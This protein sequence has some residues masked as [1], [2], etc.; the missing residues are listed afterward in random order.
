MGCSFA[1]DEFDGYLAGNILL[2]LGGTFVFVSSFQ[3]ANAFPRFSGIIVA[4][5]TGA[6]DAS[7]AIF[8]FYRM[9]YEA[10][11]GSFSVERFFFG[12]LAVPIL[13][14]VAELTYM[15]PHSYHTLPEL[16]IKIERALDQSRDVYDSDGDLSDAGDLNKRISNRAGRRMAMLGRIEEL[17]GDVD[18][19]E[20]RVRSKE[21]CL[22]TSGVWGVL[23]GLP[24]HRQMLS[25]WFILLLLLTVLQMLRMNFFIATLRAQYTFM[26][27]SDLKAELINHFFD[28]ALPIGG[29]FS[30]PLIGVLLNNL[31]VPTTFSILSACIFALGIFNCLPCTWAAYATVTVFV[32]FRPLYYSAMS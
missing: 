16:E 4:L 19:R 20:E 22:E 25:P 1:S 2:S 24:A 31:S 23:H 6:F 8:L 12:F 28:A 29:V 13:I 11:G 18:Q 10:T 21:E 27:G 32:I 15:P 3:L 17:A 9:A 7:A 26:L 14:L 5:I 30:T